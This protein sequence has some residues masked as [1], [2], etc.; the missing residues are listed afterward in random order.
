MIKRIVMTYN[1]IAPFR[2][3]YQKKSKN[4]RRVIGKRTLVQAWNI[5]M[6]LVEIREYPPQ[7]L[8]TREALNAIH[9]L[10]EIIFFN[11]SLLYYIQM[12]ALGLKVY[13]FKLFKD[14]WVVK[15]G[16]VKGWFILRRMKSSFKDNLFKTC[17]TQ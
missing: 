2:S 7:V 12:C 15:K 8:S 4:V 1:L 13:V 17:L 14:E 5:C 16:W 3:K 11:S 10:N 9:S 6:F